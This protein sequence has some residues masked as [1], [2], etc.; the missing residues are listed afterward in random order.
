MSQRFRRWYEQNT[1]EAKKMHEDI[2]GKTNNH[3][4]NNTSNT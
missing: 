2:M 1:R 3:P 4:V